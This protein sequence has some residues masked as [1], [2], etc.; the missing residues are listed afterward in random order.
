LENLQNQR[1]SVLKFKEK[2]KEKFPGFENLQRISEFFLKELKNWP[3][4][5]GYFL[6]DRFFGF[7]RSCSSK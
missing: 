1:T 7:L 6:L 2:T 5:N 4:R 3:T